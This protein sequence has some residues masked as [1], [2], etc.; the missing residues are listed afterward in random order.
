MISPGDYKYQIPK[1]LPNFLCLPDFV[2]GMPVAFAILRFVA[3]I[4]VARFILLESPGT[5]IFVIS[6]ILPRGPQYCTQAD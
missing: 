2:V 4:P 1:N 6:F 5:L 3:V